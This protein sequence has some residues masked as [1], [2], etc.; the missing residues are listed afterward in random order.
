[1]CSSRQARR[2]ET[3]RPRKKATA[4]LRSATVTI[5]CEQLPEGI[6]LQVAL[7]QEPLDS[8]VLRLEVSQSPQFGDSQAAVAASPAVER[9]LGD[10]MVA[11]ELADGRLADLGLLGGHVAG[12]AQDRIGPRQPR[13]DVYELRQ[14]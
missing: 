14:A 12:R 4:S 10:A 5:F 8:S 11:A 13:L 6:N 1:M 2:S 3:P 9:V 7:G